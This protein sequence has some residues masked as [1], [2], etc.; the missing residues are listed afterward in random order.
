[1][2]IKSTSHTQSRRPACSAPI[3][4]GNDLGQHAAHERY[5]FALHTCV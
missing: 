5:F 1:L 2:T 4:A 3:T